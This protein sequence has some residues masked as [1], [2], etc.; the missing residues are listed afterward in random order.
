LDRPERIGVAPAEVASS[1]AT[2]TDIEAISI[3]FRVVCLY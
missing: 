3:T 1:A 2:Q